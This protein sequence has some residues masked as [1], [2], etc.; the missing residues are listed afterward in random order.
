MGNE[1]GHLSNG[2]NHSVMI[3]TQAGKNST[4]AY[5]SASEHASLFIG[6]QAGEDTVGCWSSTFIGPGAG[7]NADN[8]YR[9]TFIGDEA[10]QNANSNRSVGIG[11]N[12][13]EGVVGTH[14]IEITTGIGHDGV[15]P[16]E[17]RMINGTVS[18]ALNIGDFIAGDTYNRRLSIG[19]ATLSPDAVLSVRK[20]AYQGHNDTDYIQTWWCNGVK[21]AG[22]TCDGELEGGAG[23]T[24]PASLIEGLMDASLE[25]PATWGSKQTATMTKY[26]RSGDDMV[27]DGSAVI[28]NID[29]DLD[30]P[31]S[32]Y[33][34]ARL[35][36]T[37]YRPIW[38]SCN[39][40][41][42]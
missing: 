39:G 28:T 22:L 41:S 26:K 23:T 18:N 25:G 17:T 5:S 2:W 1:A 40:H 30:I 27:A 35:I 16:W 6:H 36:G 38:V 34:I 12:A 7:F 33:V 14:N 10:G 13:L 8:S 19:D 4:I 37:E 11:D 24:G 42:A 29:P 20:D 31:N 3:G 32:A 21:V 15:A 9:S